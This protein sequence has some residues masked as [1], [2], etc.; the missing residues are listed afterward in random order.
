MQCKN[1]Y[2]TQVGITFNNKIKMLLHL[3]W[4]RNF[5]VWE[6]QGALN[7]PLAGPYGG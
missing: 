3:H 4:G 6:Y 2:L 5:R 1:P 7:I